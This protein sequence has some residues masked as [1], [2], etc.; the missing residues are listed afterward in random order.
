MRSSQ[1]KKLSQYYR[2]SSIF[3]K[4]PQV[5]KGTEIAEDVENLAYFSRAICDEIQNILY[6]LRINYRF[7]DYSRG[8]VT[9]W[10]LLFLER[11]ESIAIYND[12]FG[13]YQRIHITSNK[14]QRLSRKKFL[15]YCKE[16]DDVLFNNEEKLK[17]MGTTFDDLMD[18]KSNLIDMQKQLLFT[19]LMSE[20]KVSA[21]GNRIT[22]FYY[23][24]DSLREIECFMD[25]EFR[26]KNRAFYTEY[27]QVKNFKTTKV[28]EST[29]YLKK[30]GFS[31]LIVFPFELEKISQEE[32]ICDSEEVRQKEL[33]VPPMEAT[34][35][36]DGH[37]SFEDMPE[38]VYRIE[39]NHPG[40]KPLRKMIVI[41]EGQTLDI[42]LVMERE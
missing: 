2:I 28:K 15:E 34:S 18:F 24:Q 4:Y 9:Q 7:F 6:D 14:L 27:M 26:K 12:D 41:V 5:W 17:K 21:L 33:E 25:K 39:I 11:L 20:E 37:F 3:Y 36:D 32:R 23:L 8:I 10:V 30:H 29:K 22:F 19:K 16:F 13:L 38:G 40:Y 42:H 31:E 1:N 35:D